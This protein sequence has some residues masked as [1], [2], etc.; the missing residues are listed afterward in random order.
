M[1]SGIGKRYRLVLAGG[2][3]IIDILRGFFE[4]DLVALFVGIV[5]G[6]MNN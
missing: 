6:N 1:V 3:N 5:F 4:C 2:P